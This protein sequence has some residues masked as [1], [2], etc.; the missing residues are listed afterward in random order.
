MRRRQQL[1]NGAK[2]EHG[3]PGRELGTRFGLGINW[4]RRR[5]SFRGTVDGDGTWFDTPG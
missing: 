2:N 5:S 4:R 3:E 1:G